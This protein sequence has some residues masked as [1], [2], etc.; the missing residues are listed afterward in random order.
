M[1][2][3]ESLLKQADTAT[4]KVV[5]KDVNKPTAWITSGVCITVAANGKEMDLIVHGNNIM[6]MGEFQK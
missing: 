5:K 2:T 6:T 4:I 3:L 1:K